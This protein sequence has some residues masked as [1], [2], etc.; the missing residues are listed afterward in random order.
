MVIC[1]LQNFVMCNRIINR[2][3]AEALEA[4]YLLAR[5]KQSMN[6]TYWDSNF[7][8]KK[9]PL[10]S[11]VLCVFKRKRICQPLNDQRL[12]SSENICH[13]PSESFP[14]NVLKILNQSSPHSRKQN[15]ICDRNILHEDP[16]ILPM[17]YNGLTLSFI[18]KNSLSSNEFR[19]NRDSGFS[20]SESIMSAILSKPPH[21]EGP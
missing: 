4:V 9:L 18:S 2:D 15:E 13:L 19:T 21:V 10:L 17:E 7:I 1:A 5:M 6:F 16:K 11:P 3:V 8:G 12:N 20:E 14:C